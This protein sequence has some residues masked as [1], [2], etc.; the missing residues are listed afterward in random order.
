MAVDGKL[1]ASI[2]NL[3]HSVGM[4]T[5]GDNDARL[6]AILESCFDGFVEVDGAG[7]IIGWNSQAERI[8]GWPY[9]EV[10]QKPVHMLVPPRLRTAFERVVQ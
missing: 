3:A 1:E 5:P 10:A 2:E 9:S 4:P 8:F 6:Q 7:R